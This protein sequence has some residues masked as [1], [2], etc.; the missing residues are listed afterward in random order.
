MA[1][2]G[3]YSKA[4]FVDLLAA[5][6]PSGYELPASLLWRKYAS[7]FAEKV[8]SDYHGNSIAAVNI[9]GKQRLL[10][11]GH[12]DELGFIVNFISEKGFI[13]FRPIGGHDRGII[14][15]RGVLIYTSSGPVAG[16][17]GKP[18]DAPE[19]SIGRIRSIVAHLVWFLRRSLRQC[20][21]GFDL[22]V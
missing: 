14:S 3:D 11:T 1:L 8:Y 17:T 21:R 2:L 4:F 16:V 7:Q 9:K 6:S 12:I 18:G 22:D 10:F 5:P 15:G 19:E 13:Y 20:S